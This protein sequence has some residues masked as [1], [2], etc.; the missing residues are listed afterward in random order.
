[1]N[2]PIDHLA[3]N[4]TSPLLPYLK[5]VNLDSNSILTISSVLFGI[6]LYYLSIGNINLGIVYLVL[7]Y[8]SDT[9]NQ[10][11]TE[12]NNI[13]NNTSFDMTKDVTFLTILSYILFMR[14]DI[15]KKYIPLTILIISL[16]L[17]IINKKCKNSVNS[18]NK[19]CN[20]NKNILSFFSKG[21][22][23]VIVICIIYYLDYDQFNTDRMNMLKIN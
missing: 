7:G 13:D 20:E 3:Q 11:Y 8:V 2:N 17:V 14:Y 18:N 22:F 1:M 23:T 4:I 21:T 10:S 15:N 6:S 12:T 19:Q 5:K 16:L 9:I